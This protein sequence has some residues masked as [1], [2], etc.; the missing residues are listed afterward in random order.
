LLNRL[1]VIIGF[2]VILAIG[3]A[4]FVPR[5]IQWGDYRGRLQTMASQ[6]FGTEVAIEGDIHLT[7]LPQPEL[8]FTKVRVGPKDAPALTVDDVKAQFSLMDFL[9]DRYKVTGL[10]IEHPV[11]NFAIGPDGALVSGII[12]ASSGEQSN[13][14][15][16]DAKV[17]DG[18][19]RLTDAR[20]GGVYSAEAVAGELKL[21]ALMGPFTFQGT[22]KFGGTGYGVR[23][24]TG[25]VGA[26]GTTTLSL[27]LKADDDAFTL[28]STGSLQAGTAPKYTGDLTYRQ[29]PPKPKKGET[30]DAGRG[31]FVLTGKLEAVADRVLFTDYT[32]LPDE[33]R[34]ATRLTGAA[35]LKLGKDMSFNAIVSGGVIGLPP[36]D[37]TTEGADPP[38]ELVRLL[39]ETPLPPIPGIPG[40]IGMDINELNLRAVSLRNLRL[41]ASTDAQGWTIK[42]FAATLPGGTKVGLTGSLSAVGDKPVFS[43]GVSLDTQ[44]LDLLAALWRKPSAA[45]PLFNMPGSLKAEVALSGDTLTFG[46]GTLVVAGINQAFDAEIAY[47]AQRSLKLAAHFTTLGPDESAAIAAL[48]PDVSGSGSFGATFPTGSVDL[49]ASKATLFGLEGTDLAAQATWEGGVIEFSKLSAGDLGGATFEAQ[50]TAFGTLTKPEAS[51]SAIVK[52]AD[53]APVVSKLL[54]AVST[55]PAVADF[56]RRSLPASV[57]LQLDAPSGDGGQDLKASGKLGTADVALTAKLGEG[58][59]SALTA[60]ISATLDL[61][62]DSA[63]LMTRQLGLGATP[64]LGMNGTPLHLTASVAGKPESSY[65]TKVALEG[66]EDHFSFS[67]DVVPGD[68]TR[69][70]GEGDV[71]ARIG[72]PSPVVEMLG[73]GGIHVPGVAG[74]AHLKFAGTESLV[75]TG[76]DVGEARGDLAL[77][78]R[79]DVT[80]VSGALTLASLDAWALLPAVGGPASTGHADGLW[81]DGPID[82][83]KAPRTSDGRIDVKVAALNAGD[84]PLLKDAS[85]GFDWDAQ[86]VHVR[87]LSGTSGSGTLSLDATVCCSNAALPAKRISGRLALSGVALE[88]VTPPPI[89]T[90]LDGTIDAT[91]QFDGTGESVAEAIGVMTGT[92]SYTIKSLAAAHFDPA[93][94]KDVGALTGL[95]DIPA[96]QVTDTV[97]VALANA[98]FT[99][100]SATGSF[101]IAGGVLRSPNLAI[102]GAGAKIFGGGNVLL[103]DLTV[104]ARYA[105]SPTGAPDPASAVDPTT[106]EVAAVVKGPLWAPVGSY[107][108]GSLVD[109]MKIRAS[110]IELAKLEQ[111]QAEADARAKAQVKHDLLVAA[112]KV[113]NS[114]PA[115]QVALDTATAKAAA[116]LAAKKAADE[117]AAQNAASRDLGM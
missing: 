115:T 13:V 77:I 28:A 55:P 27:Y 90:S 92:G 93:I 111:R 73:A 78:K 4:F 68:F 5:F 10:T 22:T 50:G 21:D 16:A 35:E 88:A 37:A 107:D 36:R 74:T 30:I 25:K 34:S 33:N 1:F 114:S 54:D 31:D 38:Y 76:I 63:L 14:S 61:R 86:S 11:V 80:A 91:A 26:D 29:P 106:A 18:M 101:T 7:L 110:E 46:S 44:R 64:I 62:S 99:A 94:F 45:N 69:I 112:G 83:G 42:N 57:E 12:I 49:S 40:T 23:L 39:H 2:L 75:L 116:D 6:A 59:A 60:Q 20:S 32:A 117:K 15:I 43:G 100:S 70:N 103:K 89:G 51:G 48:L 82:I 81:P 102:E 113:A 105:M 79:G 67:G 52:V 58:I 87:N 72:D 3:A 97:K 104:D 19:V 108:V 65:E 95:V 109:G 85:F 84:R 98:P 8:E 71:E 41:D 53:K 9:S 56:L 66:G 24:S 47:G 96:E 17:V